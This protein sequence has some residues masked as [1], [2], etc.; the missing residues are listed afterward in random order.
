MK[1]KE[2]EALIVDMYY[3]GFAIWEIAKKVDL[4]EFQVVRILERLGVLRAM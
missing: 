1:K 2:K 3:K 4:S